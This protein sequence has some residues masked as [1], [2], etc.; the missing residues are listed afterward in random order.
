MRYRFAITWSLTNTSQNLTSIGLGGPLCLYVPTL[1][2][3][4]MSLRLI[5]K[6]VFDK[7]SSVRCFSLSSLCSTTPAMIM[8][9]FLAAN[10]N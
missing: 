3:C 9:F 6:F 7:I 8:F 4:S 10:S 1:T 2:A 5:G